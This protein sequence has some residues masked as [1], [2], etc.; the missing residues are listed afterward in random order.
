MQS[1][2][3]D[4]D[5]LLYY[6]FYESLTVRGKSLLAHFGGAAPPA[7]GTTFEKAAETLQ[8]AGFTYDFVSDRQLRRPRTDNGRITTE[9]RTSYRRVVLPV[10][11]LR[12]ARNRAAGP[13]ARARRRDGRVVRGAGRPT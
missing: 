11:S 13:R 9:G 6:P 10:V 7:Q 8:A 4:T 12:S 3:P 2:R 5:V 1:G